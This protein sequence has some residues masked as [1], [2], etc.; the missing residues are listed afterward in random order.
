MGYPEILAVVQ[1]CARVDE[2]HVVEAVLFADTTKSHVLMENVSENSNK[3][4]L[5][6]QILQFIVVT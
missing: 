2:D 1:L 3:D 4:I 6:S 5:L